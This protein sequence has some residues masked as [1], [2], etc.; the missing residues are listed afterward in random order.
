MT[1]IERLPSLWKTHEHVHI[2]DLDI[3]PAKKAGTR[4]DLTVRGLR[5]LLNGGGVPFF[6]TRPQEIHQRRRVSNTALQS[7]A[8]VNPQLEKLLSRQAEDGNGE[9][10][11]QRVGDASP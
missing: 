3:E 1:G 11:G 6:F 8:I 7:E 5:E 4:T 2:E 10:P 9:G